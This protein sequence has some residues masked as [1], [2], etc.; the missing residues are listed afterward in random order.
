MNQSPASATEVLVGHVERVTFHSEESG[1]CVLRVKARGHRDLVTTVGHLPVRRT[2]HS[3]ACL[4]RD[5]PQEPGLRIPCGRDPGHDPALR[6]AAA[7]PALHRCHPRQEAGGAGRPTPGHRDRRQK[8]RRTPPLVQARRV[9]A[10]GSVR[11]QPGS[12]KLGQELAAALAYGRHYGWIA[13]DLGL[14]TNA[15]TAVMARAL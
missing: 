6:D 10:G 2:R 8:C 5:D 9:A 7:K 11:L 1:F 3:G 14:S 15:V 12:D 4:R 13:G